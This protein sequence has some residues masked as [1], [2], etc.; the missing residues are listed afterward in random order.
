MK[1]FKSI[2]F[3]LGCLVTLVSGAQTRSE[4][5]YMAHFNSADQ[6]VYRD[7]SQKLVM[8]FTLS[9][10]QSTADYDWIQQKAVQ[11]NAFETFTVTSG[12][13]PEECSVYAVTKPMIKI[14]DLRKFFVMIG[15]FTVFIDGEPYPAE[16]FTLKMIRN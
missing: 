11:Y 7:A 5:V 16:S 10:P 3:L 6:S 2:L 4:A 1:Y 9:G 8:S 13:T 15:V 14:R 12:F